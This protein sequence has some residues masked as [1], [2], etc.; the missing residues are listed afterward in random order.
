[1]V[2]ANKVVRSSLQTSLFDEATL[3]NGAI[4]VAK[5]PPLPSPPVVDGRSTAVWRQWLSSMATD[6]EAAL[7]AAF[8]YRE[9]DSDGRE[10]WLSSLE[11]DAPLVNVPKVALYAPLL[12]VE[13]DPERRD[14]LLFALGELS[15][16]LAPAAKA[17]SFLGFGEGG[18]RTY[19][20][21]TP[22]YLRFFQ[23]LACGVREGEFVWVNHDPIVAHEGIPQ[24]GDVLKG[25]ALD[26][27]PMKSVLDELASCVLSH[28]RT[29]KPLPEALSVLGELLGPLGP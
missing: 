15:L 20:V 11:L 14:R 7:A 29:G 13:S 22:L 12:A 17:C 2:K 16:E 3:A 5:K 27:A 1:M 21:A 23:V 24:A 4:P 28:Q 26:E 19:V 10:Q 25:T 9:M 18:A 8:A 6:A